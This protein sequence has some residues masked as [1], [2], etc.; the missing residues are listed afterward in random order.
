[1]TGSKPCEKDC[2]CGRHFAE[3]RKCEIG[4]NC[5]KHLNGPWTGDAASYMARHKRL[6]KAR[7]SAKDHQCV[8]CKSQAI[9]WSQKHGTTGLDFDDYEPRCRSCHKLYDGALR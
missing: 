7:G 1:M 8:D 3:K 5:K 2:L 4:C 6:H 9:D